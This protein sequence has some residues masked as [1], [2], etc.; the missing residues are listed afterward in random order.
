MKVFI[1]YSKKDRSLVEN[2]SEDIAKL[3]K[4]PTSQTNIWYDRDLKG[5][6]EWWNS[7]LDAIESC[8]VF[9]FALTPL[10]LSSEACRLER[11]YAQMLN[12]RILPIMLSGNVNISLLPSELQMIQ[13]VDYSKR[14]VPS[15]HKVS[16]AF[17]NLP[18]PMPSPTIP[19]V[20]P[21]PPLYQLGLILERIEAPTLTREDQEEIVDMLREF[22]LDVTQ[23]AEAKKLLLRLKAHPNVRPGIV[24]DIDAI[25][26]RRPI[27]PI[28]RVSTKLW[29]RFRQLPIAVQIISGLVV[30]GLLA[31]TGPFVVT[32][33]ILLGICFAIWSVVRWLY[34]KSLS[35]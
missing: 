5:G 30:L 29:D 17:L 35:L 34:Q 16:D 32:I 33:V 6:H 14:D 20:R 28:R 11:S 24:H 13:Y 15:Y 12:K 3:L 7:I 22:L 19:P 4:T 9:V 1:S 27:E 26:Q 23:E 18:A 8:D 2:L 25:L 21:K 31:I 10:S